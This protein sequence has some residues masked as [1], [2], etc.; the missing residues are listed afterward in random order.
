M[1]VLPYRNVIV[2]DRVLCSSSTSAAKRDINRFTGS[3][4]RHLF[5]SKLKLCGW[6]A[7]GTVLCGIGLNP[8]HAGGVSIILPRSVC[9][10]EK[11]LTRQC[12]HDILNIVDI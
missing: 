7:L 8:F 3:Y 6:L 9:P 11:S 5:E 4:E 12:L 1:K 10:A 2:E